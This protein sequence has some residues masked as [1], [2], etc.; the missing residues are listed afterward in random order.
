MLSAAKL[1]QR[2]RRNLRQEK[3]PDVNSEKFA[4]LRRDPA[5]LETL[6]EK[7]EVMMESFDLDEI[8]YLTPLIADLLLAFFEMAV[9]LLG[10]SSPSLVPPMLKSDESRASELADFTA[11]IPESTYQYWGLPG[12][13]KFMRNNF[14]MASLF[15][16]G[17]YSNYFH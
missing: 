9:I 15:A 5:R 16:V 3:K 2:R 7:T 8:T 10:K 6:E 1:R 12:Y 14:S 13:Q 4:E 17:F 11:S